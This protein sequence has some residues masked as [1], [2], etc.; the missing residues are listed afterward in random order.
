MQFTD[1]QQRARPAF[2]DTLTEDANPVPVIVE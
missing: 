1:Q 2:L